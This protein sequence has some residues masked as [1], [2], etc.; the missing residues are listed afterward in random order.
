M[1]EI[2]KNQPILNKLLNNIKNGGKITQSYLLSGDDKKKLEDVSILLSKVLLC[3]NKY[4]S[5]CTKCNVCRQIDSENYNELIKIKPVNDT[6]KKEEI[7]KLKERFKTESL[8]G[9]YQ[10][11]IIYDVDLLN[12]SAANSLLKFLEE[13]DSDNIAIFTTTNLNSVIGTIISRCQIIKLNADSSTLNEELV[14][15]MSMLDDDNIKLVIEYFF[16]LENNS[17]KALTN[18]KEKFLSVF[19][20]KELVKSALYVLVLLYKDMLNYK[21]FNK[22]YYFKNETGIINISNKNSKESIIKKMSLVLENLEKLKYNVNMTLF[23]TNLV[24][25]IGDSD[26]GKGS[27]N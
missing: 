16:D 3:E 9:R 14:K 27:R 8:E 21:I 25:E 6:I 22:L 26:N 2:I 12:Q 5:N 24:I 18:L 19:N 13:P 11:Y 15:D 7:I 23:M 10:I 1:E 17:C 20:T 4:E